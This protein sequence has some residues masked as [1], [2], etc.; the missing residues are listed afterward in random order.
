M[1]YGMCEL[2][3][4]ELVLSDLEIA[5]TK[6]KNLYFDN[7]AAIKIAQNPVQNDRIK[8]VEVDRHFIK[9]KLDQKIIQV[10]FVKSEVQLA[11]VLTKAVSRKS[12]HSVIGKLGMLVIYAPT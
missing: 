7:K 4:I 5:D 6:P 9:E 8:H 11:D 12:L 10:R 1:A 3:W 2:L